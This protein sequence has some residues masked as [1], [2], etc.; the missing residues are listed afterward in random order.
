MYRVA[1]ASIRSVTSTTVSNG[2]RGRAAADPELRAVRDL[3]PPARLTLGT[4]VD[5]H[6]AV[7]HDF[8]LRVLGCDPVPG[9]A[10]TLA[11][12]AAAE[13]LAAAI[14]AAPD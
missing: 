7:L 12:S 4:F 10:P 9:F 1:N 2:F 5:G 6:A 13:H 11:N 8:L 3:R 14:T